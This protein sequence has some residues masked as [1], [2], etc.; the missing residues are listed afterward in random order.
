MKQSVDFH[1]FDQAFRELRPDNFSYEGR[2]ALFEYIEEFEDSTGEEIEFDVIA[3]CCDFAEYTMEELERDFDPL[4]EELASVGSTTE[5][6]K[7]DAWQEILIEC[8]EFG[9]VIP[10]IWQPQ[11]EGANLSPV[12]SFIIQQ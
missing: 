11:I 6:E 2:H 5:R 8:G 3:L 10:V 12:Y 9:A 4:L 1:T 7:W